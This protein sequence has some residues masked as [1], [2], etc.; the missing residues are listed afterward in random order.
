MKKKEFKGEYL[1]P[2]VKLVEMQIQHH[3]MAVSAKNEM[4]D[5]LFEDN[6]EE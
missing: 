6:N 2:V 4:D 3:V 5:N 1:A